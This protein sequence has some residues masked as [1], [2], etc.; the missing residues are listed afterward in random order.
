VRAPAAGARISAL[1]S[2]SGMPDGQ[3]SHGGNWRAVLA[4]VGAASAIGLLAA[5]T[6]REAEAGI[7]AGLGNWKESE[8]DWLSAAQYYDRAA[9]SQPDDPEYRVHT[10]RMFM[11]RARIE[12]S[13]TARREYLRLAILAF[14]QARRKSPLDGRYV[15]LLAQTQHL[16]AQLAPAE[17]RQR[18][19]DAAERLYREA[20]AITPRSPSLWEEWGVFAAARGEHDQALSRLNTSISLDDHVATAFAQRAAVETQLGA[21]AQADVDRRRARELGALSPR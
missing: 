6:L 9:Q 15:R 1:G 4:A 21:D 12:F 3:A 5:P 2:R 18:H 16:S 10:G 20:V 7:V 13:P 11:E 8:R 17:D 14:D 19:L